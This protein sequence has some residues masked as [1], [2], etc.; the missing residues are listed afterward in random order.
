MCMISVCR[1][2]GRGEVNVYFPLGRC[3]DCNDKFWVILR[4]R[5]FLEYCYPEEKS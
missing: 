4:F 1:D 3:P 5:A 2:C